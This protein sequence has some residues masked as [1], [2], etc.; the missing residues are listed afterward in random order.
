MSHL[1]PSR[2]SFGESVLAFD[3]GGTD[4]KAALQD[5]DGVFHS[6][7]RV[8]TPRD[9]ASPGEA[10]IREVSGLARRYVREFPQASVRA[11][12]FVV[13]GLVDE[14]AGIGIVA[15]NLGWRNFPF[16]RRLRE[17][18]G[19][20]PVAFGHDVGLAGEAEM[21]LGAGRGL[22]DA[23]VLIIG[24][25]IAGAVFCDGRRVRAGGFAGE[26]GHSP[27]P[28]GTQC[29]CGAYGCLETVGSAGAIVRRYNERTGN[30][31]TGA[32]AVLRAARAGE[33]AAREVWDQ[34]VAALAE[35]ICQLAAVLGTEAVILGGGLSQAGDELTGPLVRAVD[36]RLSFHRRPDIRVSTLGQDAGL[37]GAALHARGML[38]EPA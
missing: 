15:A 4:I 14:Q 19:M 20:L 32:E 6:L 5:N 9:A 28:S 26:I 3:V 23:V 16:A 24:T 13:P 38:G 33:P 35:G 22:R 30:R 18:N 2:H 12:G 25:G 21:H 36:S 1:P 11:L 29:A 8:P 27:V 31:T 37:M 17:E 34:A 10:I 7:Q